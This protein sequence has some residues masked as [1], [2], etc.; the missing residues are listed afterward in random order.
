M[1]IYLLDH[2]IGDSGWEGSLR[3]AFG[4]S[5]LSGTVESRVPPNHDAYENEN[6]VAFVHSNYRDLWIRKSTTIKCQIVLVRSEGRCDPVGQDNQ[7]IYGCYWNPTEFSSSGPS[8]VVEFIKQVLG[9]SSANKIDWSLLRAPRSP[10]FYAMLLLCD[11]WNQSKVGQPHLLAGYYTRAPNNYEEWRY[12]FKGISPHDPSNIASKIGNI[13]P[14]TEAGDSE[15][16]RISK[17]IFE[18]A[19]DSDASALKAA[20]SEFMAHAK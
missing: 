6:A 12:P 15:A 2:N 1:K 16:E 7:N 14:L 8:N 20:V 5:F 11:A 9:A 10:E 17:V 19:K 13:D 3:K 4:E 18:A